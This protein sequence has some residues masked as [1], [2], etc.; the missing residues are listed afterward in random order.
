[1]TAPVEINRILALWDRGASFR[2]RL[3]FRFLVVAVVS[4][5][6]VLGGCGSKSA[7]T[8]LQRLSAGLSAYGKGNY[9]QARSDYRKVLG[10][11]HN[12]ADELQQDAWFDLGVLDQKLGNNTEASSEYHR[13]LQIDPNF[14]DALYN[15]ATLVA[16]R[17][18]TSAISLYRR[19]LRN[20]PSDA[21]V[22]W[23][24]GLLLYSAGQIKQARAL[25]RSAIRID[26]SFT[27]RLP[28]NVKL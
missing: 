24:L 23:N 16:A 17:N 7:L 28:K 25:L 19:A 13:A 15:L 21:S 18:P 3:R 26:P 20:S 27:S 14:T 9:N 5:A 10:Q 22:Q 4:S 8:P 12:N 2:P 6:L 1:M 11:I